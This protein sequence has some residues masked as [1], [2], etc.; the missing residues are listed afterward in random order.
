MAGANIVET[1]FQ[2]GEFELTTVGSAVKDSGITNVKFEGSQ[3]GGEDSIE[4]Q[5]NSRGKRRKRSNRSDK[6]C[7]QQGTQTEFLALFAVTDVNN[8]LKPVEET[9]F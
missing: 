3:Q 6:K 1:Q 9:H 5:D 7:N 2:T 4:E 8:V